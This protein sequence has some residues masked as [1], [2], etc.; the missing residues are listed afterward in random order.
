MSLLTLCT[1]YEGIRTPGGIWHVTAGKSNPSSIF[2]LVSCANK[3]PII[4]D[5]TS[6]LPHCACDV[7]LHIAS[8]TV[9]KDC[10]RLWLWLGL[11][12][13]VIQTQVRTGPPMS[14]VSLRGSSLSCVPRLLH[15]VHLKPIIDLFT[16]TATIVNLLDL[17][18]IMGCQGGMST[19]QY[20]RSVFTRA[21]RA[22]FSLSSSRK[23]IVMGKKD[24]CAVFGC[25]NY[26]LFTEKYTAKFS[27]CPKIAGKYWASISDHDHAPLGIP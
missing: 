22:N 10:D 4:G 8:R 3:Q 20:T 25:N 27:F 21:F 23:K 9:G 24:R 15:Q 12:I 7:K 2:Q 5:T 14:A 17:R 13:G 1:Q 19:I 18:S 11:C 26:R 16:D 6:P